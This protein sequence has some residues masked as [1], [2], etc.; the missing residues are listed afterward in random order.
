MSMS[1]TSGSRFGLHG[2][3][4]R[5][6]SNLA[7]TLN[8]GAPHLVWPNIA[9]IINNLLECFQ[10]VNVARPRTWQLLYNKIFCIMLICMLSV[11]STADMVA[12]S[13]YNVVLSMKLWPARPLALAMSMTCGIR[14][15]MD[16]LMPSGFILLHYPAWLPAHSPRAWFLLGR[17]SVTD[18]IS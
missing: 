6:G 9:N 7:V 15:P 2:L 18:T 17:I 16:I 5:L 3:G 8:W 4:A 14:C 13:P 12:M 11:I 10:G 1:L